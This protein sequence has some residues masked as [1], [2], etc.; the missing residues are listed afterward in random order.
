[1]K[2]YFVAGEASGDNHGAAL[3]ESLRALQPN[4]EFCGRGGP[5]MKTLAEGDFV[6][7]IDEAGVVGLWEVIKRYPNFGRRLLK[8][9]RPNRT[10]SSLS[11]IRV[12]ICASRA[13]CASVR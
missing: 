5:Q 6:N 4:V 8:S 2:L 7:W 12:S 1:M 10:L 9:S 13:S 3:M 11:T